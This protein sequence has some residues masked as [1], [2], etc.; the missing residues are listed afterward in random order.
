MADQ[1]LGVDAAQLLFTDGERDHRDVGGLEPLVAELL[2]EGHV[3]VAVDGGDHRRVSAGAEGFDLRDDGLVVAVAE[4][5]VRLDDVALRDLLRLE[6]GPEDLVRGARVDVVGAEQEEAR[7]AAAFLGHQV[8]HRGDRLL[9]RRRARIEDV[10]RQLLALVLDRIEEEPVQLL[11]HRQHGLARDRRPAAEHRRH[12][13]LGQQLARLLR[14]QRPVRG[15]IDDHWLQLLAEHASFGV[16]LVDGHQRDVLERRLADRHRSRQRMQ[17]AD[18]DGLRGASRRRAE[19]DGA[20]NGRQHEDELP[21]VHGLGFSSAR[22][23]LRPVSATAGP[24]AAAR[25]RLPFI[26]AS[27]RSWRSR[28]TKSSDAWVRDDKN[29]A[30]VLDKPCVGPRAM[31]HGRAVGRA[32]G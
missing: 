15:G 19:E 31:V 13:V 3:G 1:R 26:R 16:D 5:R 24:L 2:V 12:V 21:G 27:R 6:E 30:R 14:E 32:N 18:L 22:S 25:R 29:V 9:V 10:L 8:F 28:P 23:D 4:R 20:E 17:N 11:E 7:R